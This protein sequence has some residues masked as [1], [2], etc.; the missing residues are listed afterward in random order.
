MSRRLL[1]AATAGLALAVAGCGSDGED[2]AADAAKRRAAAEQEARDRAKP[3]GELLAGSVAP[4]AQ[5][6]DWVGGERIRKLATID[7]IRN[8]VSRKDTNV[9]S[10]AL[11]DDEALRLFDRACAN[12]YARSFRLYVLYARAAGFVALERGLPAGG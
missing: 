8:Q 4:L 2:G 5:C 3:L 1:A 11:T 9:R 7:D 10:V 12:S 6:K